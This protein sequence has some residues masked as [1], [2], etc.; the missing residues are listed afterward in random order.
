MKYDPIIKGKFKP[1]PSCGCENITWSDDHFECER[2]WLGRSAE[3]KLWST[4]R[5]NRFCKEFKKPHRYANTW[6][7]S[8]PSMNIPSTEL[9]I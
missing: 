2:C 5:W 8:A 3:F 4:E 7:E 6:Y 9:Y 1:C